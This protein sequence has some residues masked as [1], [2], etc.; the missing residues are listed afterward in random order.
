MSNRTFVHAEDRPLDHVLVGFQRLNKKYNELFLDAYCSVHK[1]PKVIL[2][3]KERRIIRADLEAYLSSKSLPVAKR[4]VPSYVV[5]YVDGEVAKLHSGPVSPE[6]I[7][8]FRP[9]ACAG[10]HGKH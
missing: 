2:T 5:A 10:A 8:F 3:D 6:G 1:K 7:R 4:V 9:P